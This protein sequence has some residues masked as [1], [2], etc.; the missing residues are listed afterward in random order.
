M[1]PVETGKK[2]KRRLYNGK[3]GKLGFN[4]NPHN[5]SQDLF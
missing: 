5:F 4:T 3:P 2:K 1:K